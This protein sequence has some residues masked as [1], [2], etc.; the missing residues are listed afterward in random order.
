MYLIRYKNGSPLIYA[1]EIQQDVQV[2]LVNLFLDDFKKEKRRGIQQEDYDFVV[3]NNDL[4]Y[5]IGKDKYKEISNLCDKF[6]ANN[7]IESLDNLYLNQI[8]AYGVRV[9]LEEFEF[10]YFGSFTM[11]SKIKKGRIL[12]N[13]NN[14]E[15]KV[16][17][18]NETLGLDGSV[19]VI[20]SG[21]EI[22]ALNTQFFERLFDLTKMYRNEC[23]SVLST[24]S[25]Y[26]VIDNMEDLIEHAIS[27][28]RIAKRLTKLNSDPERVKAFF[29]NV[30]NVEEVLN[31]PN[32]KEKFDGIKYM[33]EKLVYDEGGKHKF[34]TL[35]TDAAYKS[36]VGQQERVDKSL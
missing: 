14:S 31:S 15:L 23:K 35:I 6:V 7:H 11:I 8:F 20:W 4:F 10:M 1:P 19:K 21:N 25:E 16:I 13:L 17:K 22:L 5:K 27:D 29:E 33:D 26:A 18:R 30:N 36:I 28:T 32:L 3:S 9:C 34:I 12:A 2:E 24:I